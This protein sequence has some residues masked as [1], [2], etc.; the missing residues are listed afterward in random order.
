MNVFETMDPWEGMCRGSEY[1]LTHVITKIICSSLFVKSFV[2]TSVSMIEGSFVWQ[3]F[4]G[5]LR[6]GEEQRGVTARAAGCPG[7]Q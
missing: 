3:F 1:L 4:A 5:V 6:V 7:D 2:K